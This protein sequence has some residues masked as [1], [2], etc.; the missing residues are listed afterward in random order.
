MLS[1]LDLHAAVLWP[2]ATSRV[3]VPG[4]LGH[5][6]AWI[7]KSEGQWERYAH[8][9]KEAAERVYESWLKVSDDSLIF[10]LV[11]LYRHY[12]ELRLKE[13][14]QAASGFLGLPKDWASNH[15]ISAL[16]KHLKDLLFKIWPEASEEDFENAS[17]LLLEL[18]TEDPLSFHFRYPESKAGQK[19]LENLERIDVSSFVDAL[20]RLAC[21]LDGASM[22][23][24][25]YAENQE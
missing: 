14:L 24:S 10:P 2:D 7:P 21:F 1:P 9:Y 4:D 3:F 8:G 16:W 5:R 23:L 20:R 18:A 11:F 13:L 22:A 19:H 6:L 25:V 15:E 17:R 12:V